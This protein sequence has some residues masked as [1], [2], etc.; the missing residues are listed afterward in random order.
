[1]KHSIPEKEGYLDGDLCTFV[2]LLGYEPPRFLLVCMVFLEPIS[3]ISD[4][5]LMLFLG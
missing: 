3:G 1:M 4:K 5:P 2:V